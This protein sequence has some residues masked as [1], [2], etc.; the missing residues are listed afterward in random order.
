MSVLKNFLLPQTEETKKVIISDR[1]VDEEGNPV[2]FIVRSISQAENEALSK[3]ST[4]R[5]KVNGQ[6]IENLNTVEYTR[7]LIVACT[8]EPNF[9]DSEMCSFYGVINPMDV[10][11]KM[12][13]MGEY[14]AL[15]KAIMEINRL[16]L[17]AQE[18]LEEAKNS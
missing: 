14:K 17:D 15:S 4:K 1:F 8:V 12:L 18:V 7:R 13:N 10:P 9:K 6:V 16:D 11:G 5:E 2:P 3:A